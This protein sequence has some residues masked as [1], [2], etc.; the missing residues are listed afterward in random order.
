MASNTVTVTVRLRWWVIPYLHTVAMFCVLFNGQPN[1]QRVERWV[2][3]GL[4][5]E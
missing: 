2:M 4:Y 5:V 1:W 3:R